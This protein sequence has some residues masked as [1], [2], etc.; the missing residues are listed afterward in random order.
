MRVTTARRLAVAI[1]PLGVS[2]CFSNIASNTEFPSRLHAC[3][4]LVECRVVVQQAQRDEMECAKQTTIY[5]IAPGPTHLSCDDA[6]HNLKDAEDKVARLETLEQERRQ[7]ELERQQAVIKASQ[8]A[9]EYQENQRRAELQRQQEERR[10]EGDRAR[11]ATLQRVIDACSATAAARDIRRKHQEL[12]AQNP[13]ETVQKQCTAQHGTETVQSQCTDSNG[14]VR[15]CAKQVPTEDVVGYACSR[16]VDADVAKLGLYQLGLRDYPF[17]DDQ[18]IPV[19]DQDC[20]DAAL[21]LQMV[22]KTA[23]GQGPDAAGGSTP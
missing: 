7:K 22:P 11:A 9:R 3:H 4:S 18:A 8:Q 6:S 1:V 20:N 10:A 23:G 13:A 2:G 12:L 14:F 21:Q 16:R 15:T 5:M 19:R 17:P